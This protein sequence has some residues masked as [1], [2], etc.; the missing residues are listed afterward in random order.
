MNRAQAYLEF[1]QSEGFRPELQN[2]REIRFKF[3]GRTYYILIIEDD[4][5]LFR[6]WYQLWYIRDAKEL[7][8]AYKCASYASSSIRIGKVFVTRDEQ[9][10]VATAETFLPEIQYLEVC[11]M[12]LLS[13]IQIATRSFV[14]KLREEEVEALIEEVNLDQQQKNIPDNEDTSSSTS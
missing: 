10:V 13:I 12:R 8:H 2:E 5:D 7:K 4:E 9:Y 14:D 6:L 11:F 1:L 3:E